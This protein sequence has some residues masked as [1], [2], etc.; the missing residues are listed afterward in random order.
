MD[1]AA[2]QVIWLPVRTK[3]NIL[4]KGRQQN[5]VIDI[6]TLWITHMLSDVTESMNIMRK[7]M[8]GLKNGTYKA[9]KYI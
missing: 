3:Y 4:K 7:E 1:H 8:E 2:P 6:V 5:P 9:E